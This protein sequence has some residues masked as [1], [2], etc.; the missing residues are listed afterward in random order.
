MGPVPKRRDSDQGD[1]VSTAVTQIAQPATASQPKKNSF[2]FRALLVFS[3][4]Y[5]ARPEDVIPGLNFIPVAKIAG[6]VALLALI[7]ALM[8]RKGKIRL[9]LEVKL[10]LLLLMQMCLTIPFAYWRGGAF[11]TVFSKFS[12]GVIVAVLV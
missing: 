8:G 1:N 10:L 7:A 6:G 9:P 2:A 3:F 11:D 4:L 5:F 12:K